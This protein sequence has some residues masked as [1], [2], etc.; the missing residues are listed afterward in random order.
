MHATKLTTKNQVTMPK[1]IR[2]FL[3]VKPGEIVE[4]II[5]EDK[6]ILTVQKNKKTEVVKTLQTSELRNVEDIRNEAEREMGSLFLVRM[7]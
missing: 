5:E 1:E 2:T 7:L 3:G 4:W 6:V